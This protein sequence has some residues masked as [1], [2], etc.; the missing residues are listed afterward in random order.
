M[1]KTIFLLLAGMVLMLPAAFGKEDKR[2]NILFVFA[3]D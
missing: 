1:Q 3:D 2:P